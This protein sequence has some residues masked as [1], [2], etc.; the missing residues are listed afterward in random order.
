MY[1]CMY[2]CMKHVVICMNCAC[3]HVCAFLYEYICIICIHLCVYI[4]IHACMLHFTICQG[5]SVY[6]YI[7]A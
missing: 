5:M 3:M 7:H 4:H 1:V 6:I 2:V